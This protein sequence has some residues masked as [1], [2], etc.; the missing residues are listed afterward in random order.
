MLDELIRRSVGSLLV[1]TTRSVHWAR[2]TRLFGHAAAVEA[3]LAVAGWMI[4]P[5]DSDDPLCDTQRVASEL[6]IASTTA[7]RWMGDGTLNCVIV[8]DAKPPPSR[9]ARLS[10]V[11]SLRDRLADRVLLPD[12]AEQLGVRYQATDDPEGRGSPGREPAD[13][14]EAARVGGDPVRAA[15]PAPPGPAC[16]CAGLPRACLGGA[17]R[18]ARSDG[19]DRRRGRH[20]RA[21]RNA[22]AHPL[23][24]RA[25]LGRA[26]HV[27]AV[28]DTST[29]HL[30]AT[31]GARSVPGDVVG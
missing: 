7:R 28:S 8:R 17:S 4:D 9:W 11:W 6:G 14:G 3:T 15:R 12:L 31:R 30:V 26:R 19:R 21:D 23:S 20:V 13:A 29:R 22:Q 1:P 10:D 18:F 27:R 24:R 2:S 16:R 5:G 25:V